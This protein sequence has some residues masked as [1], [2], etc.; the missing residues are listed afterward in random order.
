[1]SGSGI[2]WAI[3]KSAPRCRQIPRQ[4]PTAHFLQAGCPS[5]RPTNSVKAL[6]AHHCSNKWLNFFLLRLC[7]LSQFVYL[8]VSDQWQM[9][10]CSTEKFQMLIHGIFGKSRHMH[11]GVNPGFWNS[12]PNPS[13]V[14]GY[15]TVVIRKK[16]QSEVEHRH[17][18]WSVL[19]G[20]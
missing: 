4:H 20:W 16:Q 5:C 14:P 1:V 8:S 3:C 18:K 7:S 19:L 13:E 9:A 12:W 6:K 2:S 15:C 10:N 17:I 11:Q